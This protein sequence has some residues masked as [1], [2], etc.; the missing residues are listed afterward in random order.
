MPKTFNPNEYKI[1]NKNEDSLFKNFRD[2]LVSDL[3]G[4]F[5]AISTDLDDLYTQIEEIEIPEVPEIPEVTPAEDQTVTFTEAGTK[6]NIATTDTIKTLFGKIAKW[7][8][9]FGALAWKDTI[10][11]AQDI[12]DEVIENRNLAYMPVDTFKGN[13]TEKAAA[14]QDLTVAEMQEVLGISC[15]GIGALPTTGGTINGSL[16]VKTPTEAA[17]AVNKGYVDALPSIYI[18]TSEPT[19][20][21]GKNGDIWILYSTE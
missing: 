7:F 17:H 8:S 5:S 11:N 16:S 14:P 1:E 18:S 2:E 15:D 12:G 3:E 21:D 4:G 9:S 19:E 6:E 13:C 10:S 20:A